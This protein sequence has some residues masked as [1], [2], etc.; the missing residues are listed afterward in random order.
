MRGITRRSNEARIYFINDVIWSGSELVV[1]LWFEGIK[2]M[3]C[4]LFVAPPLQKFFCGLY[5]V[6]GKNL[7]EQLFSSPGC[8]L[9]EG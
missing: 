3:P 6:S 1:E 9:D 4:N 5:I 7:I 8:V 2:A